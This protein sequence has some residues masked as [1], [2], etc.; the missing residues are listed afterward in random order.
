MET[1]FYYYKNYSKRTND[2]N[3]EA[4]IDIWEGTFSNFNLKTKETRNVNGTEIIFLDADGDFG[5]TPETML[6]Y[7]KAT[8]NGTITFRA[9]IATKNLSFFEADII[10]LLNGLVVKQ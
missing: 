3:A 1:N 8:E 4:E 10:E 5:S 6:G 2:E 9:V 7:S